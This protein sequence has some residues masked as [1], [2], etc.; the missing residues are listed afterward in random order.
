MRLKAVYVFLLS[1][2]PLF[3]C[4]SS[5]NTGSGTDTGKT[6]GNPDYV[7]GRPTSFESDSAMLDY[8][9]KVSLNY[10]W[11]G[12]EPTSG[13]APERIHLDGNYPDNDANVVTLGGS[14][15]GV[16]GLLVGIDRGFI[17]RQEGVARLTKIVDYLGKA[18][19]FHGAWPH[20]LYGPT[21]KV[22]P[23]GTKDDGGDLVESC[24]MMESL[25][26]VRQ[27]FKDGNASE[28]ALAT[29]ID[30]PWHGMDFHWTTR[31]GQH[32]IS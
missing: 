2:L 1:V 13:L 15:F 21:G 3:S 31:G 7:P 23:F 10:M 28:K 8:I 22:K 6:D 20:W 25:L 16:A 5:E 4:A 12:A 29:N 30:T 19:R 14:G 24:F 18:D 17:G 27:Y 32:A 26:C 9:Q 11:D